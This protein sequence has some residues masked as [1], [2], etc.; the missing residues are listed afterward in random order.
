VIV[1]HLAWP[2]PND[3]VLKDLPVLEQLDLLR[4]ADSIEFLRELD[5]QGMFPEE[6]E[7]AS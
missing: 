1:G 4:N 5:R 3:Q 6:G 2:S 7:H